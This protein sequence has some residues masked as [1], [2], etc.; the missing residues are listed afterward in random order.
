MF[1]VFKTGAVDEN[2]KREHFRSKRI[3]SYDTPVKFGRAVSNFSE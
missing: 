2:N 3:Y 1:V